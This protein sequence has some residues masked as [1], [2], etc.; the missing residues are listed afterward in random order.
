MASG[1]N[2]YTDNP[3]VEGLTTFNDIKA[4][5]YYGYSHAF[6]ADFMDAMEA[7]INMLQSIDDSAVCMIVHAEKNG[8]FLIDK[9]YLPDDLMASNG[10]GFTQLHG[11]IL[12]AKKDMGSYFTSRMKPAADL[13]N[14]GSKK[15]CEFLGWY[16]RNQS[17]AFLT[18][19]QLVRKDQFLMG[20]V[21]IS[22]H[23]SKDQFRLTESAVQ[24][25]SKILNREFHYNQFPGQNNKHPELY[26]RV[27]NNTTEG[28]VI[29]RDE[30]VVWGNLAAQKILG[31]PYNIYSDSMYSMIIPE[32]ISLVKT[33]YDEIM[34]GKSVDSFDLRIVNDD[35]EQVWLLVNGTKIRYESGSA[36]LA[37][38]QDITLR[39][40]A[41]EAL[42]LSESRYR[43][44][45][46]KSTDIFVEIDQHGNQ[47]F[48]SPAVE[49]ITGFTSEELNKPFH[50]VIHPEDI[51]IV[52]KHWELAIEKPQETHRIEYR[53]IHKTK[54]YIWVEAHGQSFLHDPDIQRV[55]TFV[56][57]I[58]D[59][60]KLEL[61]VQEQQEKYKM[62]TSN[63]SDV[64]W[65][66]NLALMRFTF[67]TPSIERLRGY[68][69]EEAMAQTLYESLVPDSVSIVKERV[70]EGL[71]VLE[72][73]PD[74]LIES[75]EELQQPCKDG[76]LVWIEVST[77]VRINKKGEHEIL[78]VSRNIQDRKMASKALFES[79][80][81][82][83]KLIQNMEE[84]VLLVNKQGNIVSS[85][86]AA[87]RIMGAETLRSR[88]ITGFQE[89]IVY[90]NGQAY[91][92]EKLPVNR[93]LETGN[94][95][96]NA[97][98]GLKVK[99]GIS[100]LKVHA[101][102]LELG[103]KKDVHVLVTFND[104]TNLK[105]KNQKLQESNAT[106]DK[107]IS[108]MAHDL[109]SSF[110][111][112]MGYTELLKETGA[113]H[114]LES[115]EEMASHT[116]NSAIHTLGLL[117]NLLEWSRAQTGSMKFNPEYLSLAKLLDHVLIMQ[118]D[119]AKKKSV[120]L[121]T[122][123]KSCGKVFAD[124]NMM[125]TILRNVISN[126]LKFT[127]AGGS[128]IVNCR[129]THNALHIS[130]QDNGIGMNQDTMQSLFLSSDISSVPGTEGEKGTGLGLN[131]CKEFV[132]QHNGQIYAESEPGKGTTIHIEIPMPEQE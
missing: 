5:S 34:E 41:E 93:V 39:K 105:L 89:R 62:I 129:K 127:H 46:N 132:G 59:R 27:L 61:Q 33:R 72:D 99:D 66:Y 80:E 86:E 95:V 107:F 115:V 71:K 108:I 2:I 31:N 109:K 82:Y 122:D 43:L 4:E 112:I 11:E 79:K 90:E 58:S 14:Q 67:I 9:F 16:E 84:G 30:K 25:F 121:F 117:D 74:A 64:I 24:N 15:F 51:D 114:G 88:N 131:I 124:R 6:S 63:I 73:E 7:M 20:I 102:K 87:E 44:L 28:I 68:T 37:F 23:Y 100:W 26:E 48:I 12:S 1:K 76:S 21:I 35:E 104:I 101:D 54:G 22:S 92:F 55:F 85:N 98:L 128:V 65:V 116:H 118:Q 47:L 130:V 83:R 81:R 57:D 123:F 60:K 45:V 125:S 97:I 40:K 120:N 78:G 19:M 8:S 42:K 17:D 36:V 69:V 10:F 49:K 119:I 50:E 75:T 94:Q 53:H 126:A 106:K 29:I 110:N 91:P 111:V 113:E 103:E 70:K 3:K 18:A 52:L 96:R 56:R 13:K 32:D 38:L 77:S